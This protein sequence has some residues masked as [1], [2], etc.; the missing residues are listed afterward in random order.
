MLLMM[1]SFVGAT[2]T[3]FVE[4]GGVKLHY[5]IDGE[6]EPVLLIHGYTV[7]TDMNWRIP[8]T[9]KALEDK[10][11]VISIDNRGHGRSDKP[12]DPAQYGATMVED[13][14]KLLDH[15][16]IEK[17]HVVG[18]SMGGL[19]TMKLLATHP[20]RVK[21]AVIGGM[22]WMDDSPEQKARYENFNGDYSGRQVSAALKACY[23]AFWQLGISEAELKA[24]KT[25]MTVI[26]GDGDGLLASRVKPLQ[27][28]RPDVPVVII[29]G[30]NHQTCIFRGPFKDAIRKFIDSQSHE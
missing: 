7:S 20:D 16:K 13:A 4:N 22:G 2:E 8:G 15:L 9:I 28:A 6:G 3:G 29:E 17:A 18:Y 24:I 30:A 11:K 1:S 26:I 23:Q 10:Y 21:S 25:P 14:V 27:A 5:S 12:E 19:I